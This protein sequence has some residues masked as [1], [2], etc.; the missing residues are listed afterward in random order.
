MPKRSRYDYVTVVSGGIQIFASGVTHTFHTIN[1]WK[2]YESTS[3]VN[4]EDVEYIINVFSP[5]G[6]HFIVCKDDHE[7]Q[8]IVEELIEQGI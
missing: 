4:P 5:T 2:S 1:N 8:A 3:I 6:D 7:L